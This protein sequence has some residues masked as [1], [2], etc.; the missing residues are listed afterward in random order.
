MRRQVT[1]FFW[2]GN[3]LFIRTRKAECIN[4][5]VDSELKLCLC[6]KTEMGM[7][8]DISVLLD[9]SQSSWE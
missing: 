4:L 3:V 2:P 9:V 7:D 8:K 1:T 5:G 6:T